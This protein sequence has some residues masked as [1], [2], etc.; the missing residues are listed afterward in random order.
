MRLTSIYIFCSFIR[1]KSLCYFLALKQKFFKPLF[2]H[3]WEIVKALFHTSSRNTMSKLN[4][5]FKRTYN[6]HKN[7]L[8][9]R[10]IHIERNFFQYCMYLI[11]DSKSESLCFGY[12][13]IGIIQSWLKK[14]KFLLTIVKSSVYFIDI[15]VSNNQYIQM[16]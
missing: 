13:H 7:K 15:K 9:H 6:R 8:L 11:R 1:V 3:S 14:S 10:S 4:A 5:S 2:R 12:I 16:Y